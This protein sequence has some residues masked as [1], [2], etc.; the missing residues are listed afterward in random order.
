MLDLGEGRVLYEPLAL[1]SVLVAKCA[2]D[3]GVCDGEKFLNRP[4]GLATGVKDSDRAAVINIQY[5]ACCLLAVAL[6][7]DWHWASGLARCCSARSS[8]SAQRVLE[9]M[10]ADTGICALLRL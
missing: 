1:R 5:E 6:H 3:I 7:D 8:I 9:G 10:L 2:V 4:S